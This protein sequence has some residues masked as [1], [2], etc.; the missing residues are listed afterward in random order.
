METPFDSRLA[1]RGHG[2]LRLAVA[3][4]SGVAQDDSGIA[5][6]ADCPSITFYSFG[7]TIPFCA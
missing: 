3:F 7:S 2:V 6:Y 1:T 4:R 5:F